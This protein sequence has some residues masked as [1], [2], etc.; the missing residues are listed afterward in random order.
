MS[1]IVSQERLTASVAAK[2]HRHV[3]P[4]LMVGWFIAYIDR[5]N[6]SYA[7]LQ[8][9][10]AL[11]LSQTAFGFGSGLFFVGYALFE[12]PS[13]MMVVRLGVRRW[14]GR[15]MISWGVISVLTVF[16]RGPL[17]FYGL[18]FALGVAEAGCFPGMAYC[19]SQW[20][21][22]RH[23]AAA[24]ASLS[25]VAML[26]GIAG[27]PLA[28]ALLALDG[29]GGL[30]G[31]QWLFACEGV[32][33]VAIGI[34]V[35]RYLPDRPDV[36]SWLTDEERLS[37]ESRQKQSPLIGELRTVVTDGRYWLWAAAF[38][39]ASAAGSAVNLF[40]PMMMR[41]MAGL[42]DSA[43]A[44]LTAVPALVG[45]AAVYW[46]GRHSTKTDER[47]WHASVPMFV[48]AL[49]VAL[50]GVSYG[51]PGALSVAGLSAVSAAAQ[52][53]LFASV[54]SAASG[55]ITAIAIAFV[56][57]VAAFGGFLGP[58]AVG[59]LMDRNGIAVACAAAGAIMALG[60]CLAAITSDRVTSAQTTEPVIA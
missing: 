46:V 55:P 42:T 36:V 59:Y 30:S 35:W 47:L 32:P 8:M 44:L 57:S 56:N 9:N 23:R 52:P 41:Q 19:L 1:T 4:L 49:G 11:G 45:A 21:S 33:A 6:V 14:L 60:G 50:G 12:I 38:F 28:A 24:L 13:N 58:Y 26:S 16:A 51:L 53:A 34:C 29:L 20:L 22:P 40:R 27:G 48:G 54:S 37:I 18:R 3:L 2:V 7:A 25:G 31:W 10:K 15:I 5:F 17:S 43:A 39:C